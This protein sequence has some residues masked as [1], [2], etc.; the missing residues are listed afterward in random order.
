MSL[1]SG[2]TVIATENLPIQYTM[3]KN[4]ISDIIL[5][6]MS[7]KCY[8]TLGMSNL[9]I[10]L[11]ESHFQVNKAWAYHVI[12]PDINTEGRVLQPTLLPC[13]YSL[14]IAKKYCKFYDMLSIEGQR[15]L[16]CVINLI[17][18]LKMDNKTA[19]L[20]ILPLGVIKGFYPIVMQ[21]CDDYRIPVINLI[22]HQNP[23]DFKKYFIKQAKQ[24]SRR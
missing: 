24:Y 20:F 19:I 1:K 10:D 14:S 18:G 13:P 4:I 8:R 9:D 7:G 21:I 17:L 22:E 23:D 11:L 12:Q 15:I 3:V 2:Y 6:T 16:L 5:K